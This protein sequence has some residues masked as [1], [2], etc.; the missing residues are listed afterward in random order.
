MQNQID[1]Q[2]VMCSTRLL[3]KGNMKYVETIKNFF[4]YLYFAFAL[5]CTIILGEIKTPNINNLLFTSS[6]DPIN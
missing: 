4:Y 2:T 6:T 5:L 3:G 1:C